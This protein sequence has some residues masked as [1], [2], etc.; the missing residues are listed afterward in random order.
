[1][2]PAPDLA[3]PAAAARSRL[4]A[5]QWR[6]VARITIIAVALYIGLRVLPTGTNLNHVDFAT[7]ANPGS[8]EL[9]DPS[10]PQFI[11]VVA[12]RS[13]VSMMIAE[14]TPD[15]R[16]GRE[17]TCV[18]RLLTA[19]KKPIGPVDLL[20]SHTRKLHLLV[21]DPSLED[22]QHI[23]PEPGEKAG[24]WTFHFTPQRAGVYR[25]FADFTPVATGRS[26]YA[27][28]D[29]EVAPSP[30]DAAAETIENVS[31]SSAASA[32]VATVDAKKSDAEPTVNAG[33]IQV[34][35]GDY[36]FSLTIAKPPVRVRQQAELAFAVARADGGPLTLGPVMGAYA[37]LVAFDELRSGF[38]HLHP[39]EIDLSQKL[40]ARRPRLTFKITIPS[41]GRYVVWAQIALE[42]VETFVPFNV[43]VQ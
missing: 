35:R 16:V 3:K 32:A 28:T 18:V 11:P 12:V 42:G 41:P 9:C 21:I 30:Q 34:V 29:L 22:Y 26:L 10:N 4:S 24:D 40:D 36:V 7:G 19:S 5:R 38:A 31:A 13:P 37:H 27:N 2:N 8:L 17:V 23:H 43:D 39:N 25:I 1:M 6:R 15:V 14:S 20:I 33:E